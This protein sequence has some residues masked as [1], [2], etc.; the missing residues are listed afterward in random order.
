MGLF[1]ILPAQS[2]LALIH[3]LVFAYQSRSVFPSGSNLCCWPDEVQIQL[4]ICTQRTFLKPRLSPSW[5]HTHEHAASAHVAMSLEQIHDCVFSCGLMM[6]KALDG[7]SRLSYA[8][9]V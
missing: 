2:K 8:C 7:K 9:C 6:L 5:G 1:V 4:K 3:P